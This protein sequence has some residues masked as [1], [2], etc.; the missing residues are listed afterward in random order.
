M[1]ARLRDW[2]VSTSLAVVDGIKTFI[3]KTGQEF[4]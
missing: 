2:V 3:I 4:K 1:M